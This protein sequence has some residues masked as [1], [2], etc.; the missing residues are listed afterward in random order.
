MS[1]SD[2]KWFVTLGTTILESLNPWTALLLLVGGS[3][4]SRNICLLLVPTSTSLL[5]IVDCC[6]GA[7]NQL[8]LPS[9]SFSFSLF[10]SLS[11][12][13]F[14]FFF[15]NLQTPTKRWQT[16]TQSCNI[17]HFSFVSFAGFFFI[18]FFSL[19]VSFWH[20]ILINCPPSF[21]AAFS[22]PGRVTQFE[23]IK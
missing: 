1:L 9:L 19:F 2:F 20:F 7:A 22:L 17:F 21:K 3:T 12:S 4:S 18:L 23:D 10:L 8:T 11:L 14:C 5:E 16:Q 13:V 15:D 6:R